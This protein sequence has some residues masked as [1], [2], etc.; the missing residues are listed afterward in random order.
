[1]LR[2][3]WSNRLE[4]LADLMFGEILAGKAESPE[5]IFTL[6]PCVLVPNPF[7]KG[8]LRQRF[9]SEKTRGPRAFAN[10]DFPLVH[11]FINDW[12]HR[13]VEPP[14]QGARPDAARS[15]E[16]HPFGRGAMT[17]RIFD[18]LRG[19]EG[20]RAEYDPLRA[21][22][23]GG[24]LRCFNLSRRLAVL[25]D[26]YTVFRPQMLMDWEEGGAKEIRDDRLLAWQP[27]LWRA[28]TRGAWR[29]KTYL[30]AFRRM[31]DAWAF[32]NA[33]P[34]PAPRRVHVFGVSRLPR[35]YAHFFT[36]LARII[37][38]EFFILNPSSDNWFDTGALPPRDAGPLQGR[39][40]PGE[41]DTFSP[42][43]MF[44]GWQGRANREF[45]VELLDRTNGQIEDHF[46]T[47]PPDTALHSLQ[48]AILE[49]RP[50]GARSAVEND[51]LPPAGTLEPGRPPALRS[52]QAHNC[53][54]P[55]REL[56][57]LRDHLLR[58]FSEEGM[59]PRDVQVQ[60]PDMENW[61]AP[62]QAVFG[63]GAPGDPGSIPFLVAGARS[64]EG[65]AEG[66][67]LK[68]LEVANG[69]F[70]APEVLDLLRSPPVRERFAIPESRLPELAAWATAAAIHWG[71]DGEHQRQASKAG[72]PFHGH[73]SWQRGIDRLLLGYATGAAGARAME[74]GGDAI[75]C[76]R[77]P[78]PCDIVEGE[79]ATLLGS[80][81][82]FTRAL[83]DLA[84]R[85]AG[86][87]PP[88]V[89]HGL[90]QEALEQFLAAPDDTTRAEL[91][92]IRDTLGTFAMNI[93]AAGVATPIP[94]DIIR[95]ILA[96]HLIA[97][98]RNT[99]ATRDAVLFCP[100]RPGSSTPRRVQCLLGMDDGVFPPSDNRAAYDILRIHRR[101]GDPSRRLDGRM[102]F[103]EA[104][105]CARDRL[106]VSHSG[107]STEG[108][109][110]ASVLLSELRDALGAPD[111]LPSTHHAPDA[112]D[113]S[114]FTGNPRSPRF[115]YSGGALRLAK[116]FATRQEAGAGAC[117]S[118]PAP[119]PPARLDIEELIHFFKSPARAFFRKTHGAP[120]RWRDEADPSPVEI[121][122]SNAL[123]RHAVNEAIISALRDGDSIE[124]LHHRLLETGALPLGQ[125]GRH[126]FE[127]QEARISRFLW[128][129]FEPER[130]APLIEI[131]R[132]NQKARHSAPPLTHKLELR[133]GD[134]VTILTHTL[135]AIGEV[136][137][138]FR[139][140]TDRPLAR[141]GTLLRAAAARAAGDTRGRHNVFRDEREPSGGKSSE[142]PVPSITV[143]DMPPGD[144]AGHLARYI[145]LYAKGLQSPLPFAP[146]SSA[147][148][149]ITL[150]KEKSTQ[151]PAKAAQDEWEEVSFATGTAEKSD[152]FLSL[153]FGEEGPLDDPDFGKTASDVFFIP[154]FFERKSPS[155]K[156]P[157]GE[158]CP[159]E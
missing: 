50:I 107:L 100:L 57:V 27:M 2:V 1:M 84:G 137:L 95:E 135:P 14:A 65:G 102:A 51:A 98:A 158:E 159:R 68:L 46:E 96:G 145:T 154:W 16:S 97:P 140:S 48:A 26:N 106:Y 101:I 7:F 78:A 9:L 4:T 44:L 94:C 28:L 124:D 144:A 128:R 104:V 86:T 34:A 3:C 41:A 109:S 21:S 40:D 118:R 155:K 79:D 142:T 99:P 80:L 114:Y 122:D 66:C 19:E 113:A 52:L 5:E 126:W 22:I 133:I 112:H 138:D 62:I 87:H 31:D 156:D 147:A 39:E 130:G 12:L 132:K 60:V 55:L 129:S 151:S 134:S 116:A 148:Y 149:A 110:P 131:L 121:F 85:C 76:A 89:W 61:A 25:F 77:L 64:G 13:L 146:R 43:N 136:P 111:A 53:H 139:Y 92:N 75:P 38:V 127:E 6:R 54:D 69:R 81:A 88:A 56:Q 152:P 24:D 8:W 103:L 23:D 49:N 45:L 123:E 42:G 71:R 10:W 117:E 29:A 17:W 143:P 115:S 18:L 72:Q 11:V 37:P 90:L 91:R 153:A 83:G 150:H 47:P 32:A 105:C 141:L 74:A 59:L 108:G 120:M 36:R 82:R 15:A 20:A 58:W 33:S 35:V 119:R 70:D 30:E 63:N 73:A 157:P 125:R 93:E 67:F